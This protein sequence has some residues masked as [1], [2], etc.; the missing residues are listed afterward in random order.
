MHCF[1]AIFPFHFLPLPSVSWFL[2]SPLVSHS[3]SQAIDD[4]VC[5]ARI[6]EATV[7]TTG[8]QSRSC[9]IVEAE[10][11]AGTT[12]GRP[13]PD[14]PHTN[15]PWAMAGRRRPWNFGTRRRRRSV[16]VAFVRQ[17]V[18]DL[19]DWCRH[20]HSSSTT[21]AISTV[22]ISTWALQS[23]SWSHDQIKIT[24]TDR[25]YC[26][27]FSNRMLLPYVYGWLLLVHVTKVF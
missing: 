23:F 5:C 25:Y 12:T 18:P 13:A 22:A 16:A 26:V 4:R 10:D 15:P 1:E 2:V 7:T 6:A 11:R 17:S 3:V 19:Q 9:R 14:L 8:R 24:Q 27:M 21:W 20:P